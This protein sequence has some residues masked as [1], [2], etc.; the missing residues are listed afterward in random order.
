MSSNYQGCLLL[1]IWNLHIDIPLGVE[2]RTCFL[3]GFQES[4]DN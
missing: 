1:E 4:S 2:N 3:E